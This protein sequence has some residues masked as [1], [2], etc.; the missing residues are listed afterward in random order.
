MIA[1]RPNAFLIYLMIFIDLS[2]D[3][4]SLLFSLA[5]VNQKTP[6]S[7]VSKYRI[8]LG[9]PSIVQEFREQ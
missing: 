3:I 7:K 4:F 6:P 5:V 2:L 1:I 9:Y 8:E